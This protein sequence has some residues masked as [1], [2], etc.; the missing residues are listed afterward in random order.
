[1]KVKV[2]VRSHVHGINNYRSAQRCP[3]AV[4]SA[5]RKFTYSLFMVTDANGY[6]TGS[7][8]FQLSLQMFCFRASTIALKRFDCVDAKGCG[9]ETQHRTF[10]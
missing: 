5:W 4:G 3:Q 9:N 10:A 7:N 6:L 8:L 1:M 2:R